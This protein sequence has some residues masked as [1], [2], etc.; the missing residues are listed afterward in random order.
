MDIVPITDIPTN[1]AG[2]SLLVV[3]LGIALHADVTNVIITISGIIIPEIEVM[4]ATAQMTD[5]T[6]EGSTADIVGNHKVI[7]TKT[8]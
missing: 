4:V 8:L 3:V 1:G 5:A 7:Q 6:L 2:V